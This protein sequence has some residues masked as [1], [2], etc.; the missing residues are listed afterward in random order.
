MG[1]WADFTMSPC[2]QKNA[3]IDQKPAETPTWPIKSDSQS[4]GPL[5]FKAND[6]K[7]Q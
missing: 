5:Q 3:Q 7:I 4:K 6:L 2:A 1:K